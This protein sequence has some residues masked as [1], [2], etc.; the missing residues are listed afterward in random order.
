MK[1]TITLLPFGSS[2]SSL[3][4]LMSGKNSALF[5][6]INT[7]STALIPTNTTIVKVLPKSVNTT[8][9]TELKH[10]NDWI[11]ANYYIYG[12]RSST[13]TIIGKDNVNKLQ[14]KWML[15]SDFPIE[16]LPLI[17][18]NRGYTI[19]NGMRIM[20]FDVNTSL[21]LWKYDPGVA[22]KQ[23]QIFSHGITYDNGVIFAGTVAN[24]TLVALNATDGKLIWQSV[25]IG[26]P[27]LG[28]R[29]SRPP[30]V[31]NDIVIVGSA[32]GDN[33]PFPAVQGK[34]TAFNRTNREKIWAIQTTVGPW[35][36]GQNATINGGAATG[37]GDLLDPKT[38]IFMFLPV[39]HHLILM[40]KADLDL[41]YTLTLC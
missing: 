18:G 14:V 11:T 8:L 35:I 20:A 5:F 40:Q 32:L 16:N 9:G 27:D 3:Q 1:A 7:S 33:P 13:Q 24:A 34:V 10:R 17:V 31:W 2:S 38:E 26:D 41:I 4:Q 29:T 22:S 6:S 19:D 12:T 23:Q 36:A 39:I 25:P 30:T 21:N 28:Y 37:S 15:H